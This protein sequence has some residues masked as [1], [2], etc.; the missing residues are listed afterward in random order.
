MTDPEAS[1]G[2][3]PQLIG[4]CR[5]LLEASG[6][7]IWPLPAETLPTLWSSQPPTAR[8]AIGAR[9]LDHSGRTM[10]GPGTGPAPRASA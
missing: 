9:A 8:E 10:S 4:S 5:A 3:D 1:P 7:A 2:T 6:G